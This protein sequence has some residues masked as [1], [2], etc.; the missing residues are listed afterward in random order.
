[1]T[2]DMEQLRRE[3]HLFGLAIGR[4]DISGEVSP[5]KEPKAIVILRWM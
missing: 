1:M 3:V 4:M 2:L 5:V